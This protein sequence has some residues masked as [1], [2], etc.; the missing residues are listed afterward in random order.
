MRLSEREIK[1]RVLSWPWDG[2]C[3]VCSFGR[4]FH[5]AQWARRKFSCLFRLLSEQPF[6]TIHSSLCSGLTFPSVL[7]LVFWSPNII[8]MA[9]H[10]FSLFYLASAMVEISSLLNGPRIFQPT[11]SA[12]FPRH[13]QQ[14]HRHLSLH[15]SSHSLNDNASTCRALHGELQPLG[16]IALSVTEKTESPQRMALY[17]TKLRAEMTEPRLKLGAWPLYLY[18]Y[19]SVSHPRCQDGKPRREQIPARNRIF[20]AGT[21]TDLVRNGG[22]TRLG[23]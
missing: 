6:R 18:S 8:T 15:V 1:W 2:F 7:W 16:E 13:H 9:F 17:L 3:S 20:R 19:F 10:C 5:Y 12:D 21:C 14:S 23:S 22:G 11:L 4:L